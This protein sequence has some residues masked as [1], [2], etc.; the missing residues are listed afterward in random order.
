MTN[1][2]NCI[3]RWKMELNRFDLS[4][5]QKC[6]IHVCY[7][8]VTCVLLEEPMIQDIIFSDHFFQR[9]YRYLENSG[10]NKS[11]KPERNTRGVHPYTPCLELFPGTQFNIGPLYSY[12]AMRWFSP[13]KAVQK[14]NCYTVIQQHYLLFT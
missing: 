14:T 5:E 7:R 8:N 12:T 11:T 10:E 6:D 3:I 4:L 2:K 9:M 13:V 1:T